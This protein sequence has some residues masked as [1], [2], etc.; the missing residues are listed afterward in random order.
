MDD[1]LEGVVVDEG[2]EPPALWIGPAL[3]EELG[4]PSAGF[5]GA[6]VR[7]KDPGRLEE[8]KAAV[9][10]MTPDEKIVYQTLPVMRAKAMRT[11]EPA[12]MALLIFAVVTAMLGTVLVGQAI[13]RRFQP[14][15]RDNRT[16]GSDKIA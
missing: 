14:D 9:D 2:Y 7:L 8:F 13:S 1:G 11:T 4:E 12:A 3:Y 16:S 15:A 5:G 6:T 10:A